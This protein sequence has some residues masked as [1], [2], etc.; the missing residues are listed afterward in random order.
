MTNDVNISSDLDKIQNNAQASPHIQVPA[1]G[2]QVSV[3][4][5]HSGKPENEYPIGSYLQ[6]IYVFALCRT[7]S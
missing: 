6:R 4:I 1:G 2:Y 7:D 3:A 5:I